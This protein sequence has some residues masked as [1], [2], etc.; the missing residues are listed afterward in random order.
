M[1]PRHRNSLHREA[2]QSCPRL[3]GS[4]H[5]HD[6][7]RAQERSRLARLLQKAALLKSRRGEMPTDASRTSSPNA[8]LRK[9]SN[10]NRQSKF[11]PAA[12]LFTTILFTWETACAQSAT[13]RTPAFG[14]AE[15]F[16]AKR[17]VAISSDASLYIQRA[18]T[19]GISGGTTTLQI[20]PAVDYVTSGDNHSTR[21]SIGPRVGY[22][23]GL[24]DL[25]SIWTKV[26]F[27][28][29]STSGAV[30]WGAPQATQ[31]C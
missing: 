26:G 3:R 6:V 5:L 17:Q 11:L 4:V 22:N 19:S 10:M 15:S 9:H 16:G 31:S 30:G 1:T 29:A 27:S 21:F 20:A 14:P 2:D 28:Y 25:V 7:A 13:E 18:T 24:S 8:S 12:V 23:F